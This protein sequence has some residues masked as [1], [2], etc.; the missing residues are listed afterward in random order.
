MKQSDTRQCGCLVRR[1]SSVDD[2]CCRARLGDDTERLAL[3]VERPDGRARDGARPA[4]STLRT[5]AD[6]PPLVG[7]REARMSIVYSARWLGVVF[8]ASMIAIV[9]Q[10]APRAATELTLWTMGGDQEQWVKWIDT[11]V[12]RFEKQH[13]DAKVKVTYYDLNALNVA[14]NT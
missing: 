4:A 12:A 9:P 3:Y 14:L 7:T 1:G 11:L 5:L 10:S 8:I 6:H 2:G 13:P